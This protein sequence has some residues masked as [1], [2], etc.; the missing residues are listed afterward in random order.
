M[1]CLGRDAHY[2]ASSMT[3]LSG[4]WSLSGR[5]FYKIGDKSLGGN[6]GVDGDGQLFAWEMNHSRKYGNMERIGRASTT[7]CFT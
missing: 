5:T 2:V 1:W 7:V 6:G 3:W 4:V